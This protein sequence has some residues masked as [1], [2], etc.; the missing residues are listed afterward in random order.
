MKAG[1]KVVMTG[2]GLCTAKGTEP[3]EATPLTRTLTATL[4]LPGMKKPRTVVVRPAGRSARVDV[5]GPKPSTRTEQGVRSILY[6]VLNLDEDLSRFY[7]A[8]AADPDHAWDGR[9]GPHAA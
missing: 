6:R 3:A 1:P 2:A 5:L 8:A 7:E 4:A 9:R